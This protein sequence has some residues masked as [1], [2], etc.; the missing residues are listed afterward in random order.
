MNDKTS[1][2]C[3]ARPRKPNHFDREFPAGAPCAATYVLAGTPA[4][5]EGLAVPTGIV[6]AEFTALR[7]AHEPTIRT[8]HE[9]LTEGHSPAARFGGDCGARLPPWQNE[10]GS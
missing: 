2:R 6:S 7:A 9:P 8:C 1:L 10:F 3:A 4:A 5:A